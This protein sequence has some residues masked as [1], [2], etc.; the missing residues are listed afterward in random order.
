MKSDKQ[1]LALE[2][3][4][5]SSSEEEESS[6][7]PEENFDGSKHNYIYQDRFYNEEDISR[8]KREN[9]LSDRDMGAATTLMRHQFPDVGGLFD[10]LNG[11]FK[12]QFPASQKSKW[13]Q[14]LYDG[15]NHWLVAGYGFP[16]MPEGTICIYD[17]KVKDGIIPNPLVVSCCASILKTQK[18]RLR[19]EFKQHQCNNKLEMIV[20]SMQLLL[21][22]RCYMD[23]ILASFFMNKK[24]CNHFKKCLTERKLTSFPFCSA[25][26]SPTLRN[27]ETSIIPVCS[28]C[29]RP[30]KLRND[31][32]AFN[33]RRNVMSVK[34][35]FTKNVRISQL[36]PNK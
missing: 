22:L 25:T 1:R 5:Y 4:F 18:D 14:L 30:E 33:G 29:T 3:T 13:I 34:N 31:S 28:S 24:F 12:Q 27:E 32:S 2:V 9:W 8:L 10:T 17:S 6:A 7:V 11:E 36:K 35:G 19:L 15:I 26:R 23:M 16:C 20:V 21:L